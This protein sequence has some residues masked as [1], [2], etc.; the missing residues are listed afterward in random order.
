MEHR[1]LN[2]AAPLPHRLAYTEWGDPANPRVLLCIHGLTRNG[3]DF[4]FLARTLE[5]DY[6]ILCPD[7]PGRGASDN[8]PDPALY[9]STIYAADCLALMDALNVAQCDWV[10]TSMG[11]IIGMTLAAAQPARIRRL[12]LNDVGAR[13]PAAGIRR[14]GAYAGK[15][16]RFESRAQ[17]E[18]ALRVIYTPFGIETEEH[19]QHLLAHSLRDDGVSLAYDPAIVQGLIHQDPAKIEDMDLSTLWEKVACPT[20]ILRGGESDIL[21][22]ETAA[23]MAARAGVDLRTFPGIGHAPSLMRQEEIAIVRGWLLQ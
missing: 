18:A 12:V 20:L 3:R 5:G 13:I 15:K 6:R 4:D 11:G 16:L 9:T 2:L 17:A 22:A 21:D 19:W 8:F 1:V 23:A 10:G 7:M 14:I